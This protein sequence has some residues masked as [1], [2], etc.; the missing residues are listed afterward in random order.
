MLLLLTCVTAVQA[1]RQ[2]KL[3]DESTVDIVEGQDYVLK[4]GFNK[5]GWSH[6]YYLNNNEK[7][8]CVA[9]VDASCIYNF[10]KLDESKVVDGKNYPV[11][12]LK[13]VENGKYLCE[14]SPKYARSIK[15][16][17]KFTARKAAYVDEGADLTDWNVYSN[18]VSGT[19]VCEGAV[20]NGTWI[21]CSTEQQEYLGFGGN[22][23]WWNYTDTN[24]WLILA[25]TEEEV[26]AF[27]KLAMVFEK[28]FP[29][30]ISPEVFPTGKGPGRI[31][32]DLYEVLVKVYNDAEAA[33]GAGEDGIAPEKCDEI[34]ENILAA[35]ERYDKEIAPVT[36]GYY[37]LFNNGHKGIAFEKD[38]SEGNC[39][40]TEGN[41]A[42]PSAW[43]MENTKYIWEVIESE[44]PGKFYL[45]NW[46]SGHYF[47]ASAGT[48]KPFMMVEEPTLKIVPERL[49]GEWFLLFDEEHHG[50]HSDGGN[51]VVIWNATSAGNQWRFDPVPADTIDS[52]SAMVSQNHLNTKLAAL[53]EQANAEIVSVSTKNGF[54]ED[55]KYMSP[56]LVTSLEGI[57]CQETVEGPAEALFDGKLDN[58]FH[59]KWSAA[60]D[61]DD[62]HWIQVDLGQ[63]VKDLC[64][65]IT[66]RPAND[67]NTPTKV[68]IRGTQSEDGTGAYDEVLATID[69]LIYDKGDSTTYVGKIPLKHAAQHIRFVVT[70]TLTNALNGTHP[71]WSAAEMRF[72]DAADCVENP[73]F[74]MVDK[75][76]K[77]AVNAAL[78]KG[79]KELD[80]NAATQKTIDELEAAVKAF[81]KAYPDP[82]VLND[83]LERAQNIHDEAQENE[84]GAEELGFF[85][86]GAKN[87]L[88]KAIDA[89]KT[90]IEGKTLSMAEIDKYQKQ[91]NEALAIFNS[92]LCTPEGDKIYRLIG[93][94]PG[95]DE[96]GK[97]IAQYGSTICSVNA[98]IDQT[99][100]WRY[101]QNGESEI[102]PHEG[103]LNTL[104]YVQKDDKGYTF[105][106]LA[107]GLYMDNKYEGLTEDEIDDLEFDELGYSATPKHFTLESSPEAGNFL[108]ALYNSQYVNLQP[109]GNVV[110][111]SDRNDA[112]APLMFEEFDASELE[113]YLTFDAEEN[114]Y[115]IV[116][117]P[118]NVTDVFVEANGSTALKVAG[119]LDGEIQLEPYN[120]KDII[121]AGTPF[122][123]VT[124]ATE[125]SEDEGEDEISHDYFNCTLES[126]TLSDLLSM[127]Y[128]YSVVEVN[129]MVSAPKAIKLDPGYGF[130]S[131]DFVFVSEG[132]E[133]IEAGSG[134][135]NK[136]IPA[137]SEEVDYEY[138]L[139]V[140]ADITGEG[141]D[142]G[143]Q[144]VHVVKNVPTD[145]YTISGVKVRS[146]VKASAATKN[147]PKG[148]YIV[149][150][151][152]VI[153]K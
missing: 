38:R 14:G 128:N 125:G 52:L 3:A 47:G 64:L 57:N 34:R 115:Q 51:T 113:E 93:A 138:H 55:G 37:L 95:V 30:G 28:Y 35:F 74:A 10:V 65:K 117:L 56:G 43:T 145:V 121:P 120:S 18:A 69:T 111:W 104:W 62:W 63:Q 110:H 33:T 5:G 123:V 77:D 58:Y 20:E 89:V 6:S 50:V 72:Y 42:V 54:T 11:Y 17:F 15:K 71:F 2:W 126:A 85:Q 8:G 7:G 19:G 105:R 84:E 112:H 92:K 142:T 49:K 40:K 133:A 81:W 94:G 119:M 135:F 122:L 4:Q 70:R 73:L 130:I 141:T 61:K 102:T 23:S 101:G 152:K 118:F 100:V 148:I 78:D 26:S 22:P 143:V 68:E 25:A 60:L 12:V 66:K 88:Q 129:G 76:I 153:V 48:S 131:T 116:T 1:Q 79:Q 83:A 21:L 53:V 41:K 99:P 9:K 29:D 109:T 134:F 151:N 137:A 150:G 106:N 139:A 75:N 147:L 91:L 127:K 87:D 13:S 136:N 39:V 140:D 144:N 103:R 146:N 46:G 90:E 132:G 45:K 96:K 98:D 97:P 44:E 59:T 149:G 36:K 82:E 124:T 107:N 31:S 114:A 80:A 108:I 27:N 86:F 16:A 24:N 67:R 32:E